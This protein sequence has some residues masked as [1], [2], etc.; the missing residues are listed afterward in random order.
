MQTFSETTLETPIQRTNKHT[1]RGKIKIR[2]TS[3]GQRVR[4]REIR[5][6]LSKSLRERI[7]VKEGVDRGKAPADGTIAICSE[8]EPPGI[9]VGCT[10]FSQ[11]AVK[12]GR[13]QADLLELTRRRWRGS[14][15]ERK[16]LVAF[17]RRRWR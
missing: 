13:P 15:E 8:T 7:E 17:N 14:E 11:S 4:G 6:M 2:G 9:S 12:S 1:R 5:E 10:S 16:G 3:R